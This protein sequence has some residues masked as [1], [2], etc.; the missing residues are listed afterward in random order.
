M[1]SILFIFCLLLTPTMGMSQDA[2]AGS[3]SIELNTIK[4]E[5]SACTLTFL[6]TNATEAPIEK[7]V[8][9]TVLFGAAQEVQSLTLFDFG[10]LPPSRPRVRQFSVPNLQCNDLSRV[11]F[12]GASTCSAADAT[13]CDALLKATTRVDGVEVLG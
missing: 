7:M 4:A 6:V 3:V 8:F 2:N 10:T 5:A 12:N 9:E 1:R 13:V 11:L